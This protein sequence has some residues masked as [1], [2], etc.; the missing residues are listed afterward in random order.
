MSPLATGIRKKR[1]IVG[2]GGGGGVVVAVLSIFYVLIYSLD[3]KSVSVFLVLEICDVLLD[4][5][6]AQTLGCVDF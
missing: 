2:G 4:E 6:N 5:G 3:K 1:D